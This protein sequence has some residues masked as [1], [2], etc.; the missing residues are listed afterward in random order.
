M[1]KLPQ[2]SNCSK[3]PPIYHSYEVARRMSEKN[4]QTK[5]NSNAV[6]CM[7]ASLLKTNFFTC[8]IKKFYELY[9]FS[10]YTVKV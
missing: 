4:L 2:I 1:L 10:L 7:A 8:I 9:K 3:L 5:V 6:G